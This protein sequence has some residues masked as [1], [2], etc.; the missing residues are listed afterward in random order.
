MVKPNFI[1]KLLMKRYLNIHKAL[2]EKTLISNHY[3][4]V[5]LWAQKYKFSIIIEEVDE[6][7]K[8]LWRIGYKVAVVNN[9]IF[10]W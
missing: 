6:W 10:I 1:Q 2:I 8:E 4:I 3:I 5:N 9:V 7:I